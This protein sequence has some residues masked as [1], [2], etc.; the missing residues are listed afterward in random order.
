[1][2]RWLL[3]GIG[4]TLL[5]I[6]LAVQ[7]WNNLWATLKTANL[8]LLLLTIPLFHLMLVCKTWRWLLLLRTAGIRY[9]FLPAYRSYL[10]GIFIGY[11]T[12]GRLGDLVRV[13]YLK[14]EQG[15]SISAGLASI[16]L[17]RFADLAML[18]FTASI[19]LTALF[20][21]IYAV[22]VVLLL[23]LLGAGASAWLWG[24][25][26]RLISRLLVRRLPGDAGENFMGAMGAYSPITL[27]ALAPITAAAYGCYFLLCW[28]VALS[29]DLPLSYW[30]IATC[31]AAIGIAAL[32]PISIGGFGSREALLV[33][34]FATQQHSSEEAFAYSLLFFLAVWLIPGL[35][36]AALWQSD[37]P[38]IDQLRAAALP[39][40]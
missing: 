15:A 30:F 35:T 38:P 25:L 28:L 7:D 31:I 9:T 2:L 11:V 16:V 26:V 29:L 12:P 24:P 27:L 5:L 34:L 6:I 23:L 21:P 20:A 13:F 33:G 4:L 19:G 3:R 37:P 22:G 18:I 8:I 39:Q 36:G 1:M 10:V 14:R 40:Q 32:L 17:D